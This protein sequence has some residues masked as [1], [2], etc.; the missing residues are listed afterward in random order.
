[1]LQMFFVFGDLSDETKR[2]ARF[3]RAIRW[4]VK[5]C[6]VSHGAAKAFVGRE[7]QCFLLLAPNGFYWLIADEVQ[8][9]SDPWIDNNTEFGFVGYF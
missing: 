3:W 7:L 6:I 1:M 9:K 8:K 5:D 2:K 4:V